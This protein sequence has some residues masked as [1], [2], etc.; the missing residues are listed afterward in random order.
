MLMQVA[1]L[2][3]PV[4]E[5]EGRKE[6]GASSSR[7]CRRFAQR[8]LCLRDLAL[9][10]SKAIRP[11]ESQGSKW[12]AQA[13]AAAASAPAE[14][15]TPP[16]N[17]G[18]H[19]ATAVA[20]GGGGLG[21]WGF[22]KLVRSLA[23]ALNKALPPCACFLQ[24]A[25]TAGGCG[26]L[27]A[28]DSWTLTERSRH[29]NSPLGFFASEQVA[30]RGGGARNQQQSST[31]GFGRGRSRHGGVSPSKTAA[32][33]TATA[34]GRSSGA[35]FRSEGKSEGRRAEFGFSMKSS[36]FQQQSAAAATG[37][38]G[39][40]GGRQPSSCRR[41][42]GVPP[43]LLHRS[44]SDVSGGADT[45]EETTP[46]SE[47]LSPRLQLAKRA[48]EAQQF[49]ENV[50]AAAAAAASGA[51]PGALFPPFYFVKLADPGLWKKQ[52][53]S[54]PNPSPQQPQAERSLRGERDDDEERD[55]DGEEKEK[56]ADADQGQGGE[57]GIE[58]EG[59]AQQQQQQQQT[60]SKD[61]ARE[62]KEEKTATSEAKADTA[63][64][65]CASSNSAFFLRW[66]PNADA[67]Y[68]AKTP[69]ER[70]E[71]MRKTLSFLRFKARAFAKEFATSQTATPS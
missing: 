28:G 59:E 14:T 20:S 15:P 71:C 13:A 7:C 42:T 12:A 26:R 34:A 24:N 49:S 60:M 66:W 46:R 67:F 18:S 29:P 4:V 63:R 32:T 21:V 38:E 1:R 6:E 53:S 25:E 30:T 58:E 55:E 9:L 22:W 40:G 19:S 3:V 65:S 69:A 64:S 57:S 41:L 39:G 2:S 31:T 36:A 44:I 45:E 68:K 70:L 54:Q 27:C 51:V 43:L 47:R 5:S 33:P 16:S 37:F 48:A 62:E 61:S 52:H 56:L 23:A 10:H 17:V 11:S 35:G 8:P 50:A